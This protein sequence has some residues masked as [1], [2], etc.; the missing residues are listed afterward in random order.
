VSISMSN[1]AETDADGNFT[2]ERVAPGSIQISRD[3]TEQ[4]GGQ[5][6]TWT[7]DVGKTQVTAGQTTTVEFGGVGRPV[8]GKFI[9]PPGMTPTD[10]F[11]NARAFGS[12][13]D[14]AAPDYYFLEV[15]EQ[16]NFRI[17]NVIPGDYSINVGLQKVSDRTRTRQPVPIRFTM[18]E[19]PGGVSDEPLVI[20]D[21]QL[22]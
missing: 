22:Q 14:P 2:L 7:V 15:D 17:N 11:F 5:S 6:W 1:F 9:F 21:I 3:V 13:S 18:P 8:V 20:P 4:S 19:V 10:Y 16:N 12:G